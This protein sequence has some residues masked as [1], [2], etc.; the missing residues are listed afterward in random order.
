[1][2]N[3]KKPF[4]YIALLMV[5]IL[6]GSFSAWA[7]TVKGNVVD[8]S[9]EPL[10]GVTVRVDGTSI[11]TATDI[12]GN[13]T[14]NVPNIK[15][16]ALI[17]SYVGMSEIK[18]HVNGRKV[19]NVTMKEDSDVLEE[20]VVVGYGQQKKASVVG[21]IT[22]TS[23][24]V[25]ERAA[26]VHDLSAALT[27]NL[28]G[29]VTVQ[30]S[31]MPGDESAKIT[32]RGASSWNNSE[33]LV[34]VD[35]V[36][37]DMSSVDVSSVK[38]ISVLKDASATAVY[39]VKGANGVILI[40]TR[41][42]Q[43]GRA[44][45]DV[46]FTA[47]MKTVSKLPDKYDSYG[48]L[49]QRNAA[50]LHELAVNP[51][52]WSY[53]TPETTL[54]KYANPA[55][56][57]EFE[58]YPNVDWQKELFKDHAMSYNANVAISGGTKFVRYY[59]VID[60]VNEGDL[61]RNIDNGRGY[62]AG[63]GYN[64]IN[65]RSN[66]DFSLTKTTTLKVNI[67]GSNGVK[68]STWPNDGQSF[69]QSN[70]NNQQVWAGVY[71]IAPDAFLPKYSDGS[72]GFYPQFAS[73]VANSAQQL[74][75]GGAFKTTHT[76][77]NTDFTLEQDLSFITK[78]L[79][80]RGLISWDNSFVQSGQGVNDLYNTVKNKWIDPET[81]VVTQQP[82]RNSLTQYDPEEGAAWTTQGGSVQ[83]WNTMRNL[84]YQV[85]L[86]WNRE[87]G[88]NN[89]GV[90]GVWN[91]Q[92]MATGTMIPI[93]R[94]DWV[95]RATYNF[96]DRYFFEYNGAYNGSEKFG[97][98][99]RFGFFNSGALGWRP[100]QEKF[101]SAIGLDNWW[102]EL[103]IR[104]SYGE[105]GDDSGARF[106]YMDQWA[107]GGNTKMNVQD[108]NFW[109][110]MD[111]QSLYTFYRQ[112]ALGNPNAHWEKVTKY[113]LGI[114]FSFLNSMFAGTV[115]LF[116]D[117]RKDILINGND[118][119]VP[120]YFG[121]TPPTAN[122]GKAEVTGYELELR[123]NKQIGKDMRVWANASMTH[124][125]NKIID[126]DDPKN[127]P[128][129]QKQAG[130]VIGQTHAHISGQFLNTW[131]ALYG[132]P[133]HDV[134]DGHRLPGD[135]YIVDF[136]GDGVIDVLDSAPYG[137]SGTPQ[138]T[139]N[140]TV[141]FEWKGF[142][143]FAQFYGVTGVTRDVNL[144]SFANHIDN[145]YNLGKWWD[146]ESTTGDVLI[147]RWYSTVSSYSNG[148]QYLYDASYFRL[149][150]VEVAYTWTNGWI[151][152]LGL[153]YLKIYLNGNNLFLWSRMPD[154]R[155]SNFSG[156]S[157]SGAYPTMRRFNF[158]IKFNL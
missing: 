101:W 20:V 32:I 106:L 91:R 10:I 137:Y 62:N 38:S 125:A 98:G 121:Q 112:S 63:F 136:N 64:R 104:A 140:A 39:G 126:R 71:N 7:D 113:N 28:P 134:N 4:H 157:G 99:F 5:M 141:G 124:A 13:Y 49:K 57:E 103:K 144:T 153:D 16:D 111:G 42:G 75:L 114:D 26:G 8:E 46:G 1:M 83:N 6:S 43:E 19:I 128:D 131:D 132:S 94:E 145:V 17:F 100:S 147:P 88:K 66:L 119:S 127:K 97:K 80:A 72:W 154:D 152:K 151:K 93:H 54:Q 143:C 133:A 69:D 23:G 60:F 118:R 135:Y 11:G 24:E 115:E 34:L 150:N 89:V 37:R 33:P 82:D 44:K 117:K 122:L 30:S 22:Q 120:S 61:F 148:T 138:N 85:Q 108:T 47:T 31:G 21:A 123:F 18:E 14:I 76:R 74:A 12:D 59:A 129:Y 25:L 50:I 107:Y 3:V 36:E 9:G 86:N 77:I 90:T 84:Y 139:Y 105:I 79:V 51:S 102:Q 29:V 110:N 116:K 45:I 142:S 15:K 70:W 87:F 56:L 92:E 109:G 2:K 95:F 35:G 156:G 27:G 78:G 58:R 68:K 55:N 146:G 155:E 40:T 53:M 130:Y 41:R 96:D 52:S 81:G 73:Q 149:K 65:A 67:A 158:G 48:S